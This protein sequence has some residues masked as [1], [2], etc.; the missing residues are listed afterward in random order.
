MS[1]VP[2]SS[3]GG[4]FGSTLSGLGGLLQGVAAL[5]CWVAREAYGPDNPKWIDFRSWMFR[6]AP[7][8][9]FNTYMK[10]G[11][12]FAKFISNKPKIKS[13]IRWMMDKA[14]G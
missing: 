3:G 10:H 2:I 14:I 4:G 8:W 7:D 13:A 5:S 1:Q 6:E 11:E 12:R 9:L